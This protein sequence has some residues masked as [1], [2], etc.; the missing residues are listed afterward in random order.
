MLIHFEDLSFRHSANFFFPLPQ[1][2]PHWSSY[3]W[4]PALDCTACDFPQELYDTQKQHELGHECVYLQ[5]NEQ[6]QMR[7]KIYFR[8]KTPKKEKKIETEKE[9][10]SSW[11]LPRL[12]NSSW[13]FICIKF[14][15]A[16][17]VWSV[18]FSSYKHITLALIH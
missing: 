17:V 7:Q 3:P 1:A 8:P 14:I 18:C 4:D 9:Q 11:I 12:W 10:I 5:R 13:N 2:R 6:T 16:F 15:P